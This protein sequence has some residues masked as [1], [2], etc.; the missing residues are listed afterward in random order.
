[1]SSFLSTIFFLLHDLHFYLS[2]VFHVLS[3]QT[4]FSLC[5]PHIPPY[6]PA[7][8]TSLSPCSNPLKN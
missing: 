7:P 4:S 1:L 5:V 6:P 8:R 2:P 3:L